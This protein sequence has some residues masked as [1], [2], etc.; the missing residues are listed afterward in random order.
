LFSHSVLGLFLIPVNLPRSFEFAL[1]LVREK[2]IS[3]LEHIGKLTELEI[4]NL[5][6]TLFPFHPNHFGFLGNAI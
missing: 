3:V 6:K 4:S 1:L 2:Y 5:A